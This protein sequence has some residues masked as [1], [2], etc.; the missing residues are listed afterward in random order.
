MSDYQRAVTPTGT[1][2]RVSYSDPLK[3]SRLFAVENEV[4]LRG[5][6]NYLAAGG[7]IEQVPV[8]YWDSN[9][10]Y[11]AGPFTI[12][13]G[14]KVWLYVHHFTNSFSWI[15][16]IFQLPD[17]GYLQ[18]SASGKAEDALDRLRSPTL[19]Q[20]NYHLRV[21]GFAALQMR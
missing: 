18:L 8:Y 14:F 10:G 3:D 21:A 16:S 19:S 9:G 1:V 5:I 11:L 20:I 17:G 15:V 6:Y 13:G 4:M 7:W 12:D 2:V